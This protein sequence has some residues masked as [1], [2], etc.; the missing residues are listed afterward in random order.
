M[1]NFEVEKENISKTLKPH[2][3]RPVWTGKTWQ[4]YTHKLL[5]NKPMKVPNCIQSHKLWDHM[6]HEGRTSVQQAEKFA[7]LIRSR[8]IT[9]QVAKENGSHLDLI[10]WLV[11]MNNFWSSDN[12]QCNVYINGVLF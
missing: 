12:S 7:Y 6:S 2:Q 3:L 4:E 9:F 5:S 11:V 8:K 1:Q 10:D